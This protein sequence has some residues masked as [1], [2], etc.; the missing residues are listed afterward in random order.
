MVSDLN[1]FSSDLDVFKS[2]VK[3]TKP[4]SIFNNILV[5]I[6]QLY[7]AQKPDDDRVHKYAGQILFENGAF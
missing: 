6:L 2:K 7:V 3:E 1:A 4:F 5:K